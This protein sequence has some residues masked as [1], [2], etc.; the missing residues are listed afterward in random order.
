MRK[1]QLYSDTQ[2]LLP[3][4][5]HPQPNKSFVFPQFCMWFFF[6]FLRNDSL[7]TSLILIPKL[8]LI[9]QLF[10]FSWDS[11]SSSVVILFLYLFLPFG[12]PL[13]SPCLALMKGK[14]RPGNQWVCQHFIHW[15]SSCPSS[16]HPSVLVFPDDLCNLAASKCW[17]ILDTAVTGL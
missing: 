17:Q 8:V 11:F 4:E 16:M 5:L 13:P 10:V 2:Y 14:L 9:I 15:A 6:F 12:L 7:L 3:F 1:F